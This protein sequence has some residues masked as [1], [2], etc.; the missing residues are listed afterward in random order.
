MAFADLGVST[1]IDTLKDDATGARGAYVVEECTPLFLC[2]VGRPVDMGDKSENRSIPLQSI[3]SAGL[4]NQIKST[5][6]RGERLSSLL[7]R[8]QTSHTGRG[9]GRPVAGSGVT[10]V[11][12]F[13]LWRSLD[14]LLVN[15]LGGTFNTH[16]DRLCGSS[17]LRRM[18]GNGRD[19]GSQKGERGESGEEHGIGGEDES[20]GKCLED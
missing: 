7:K 16:K 2:R 15:R 8:D 19:R 1:V 20:K 14:G 12:E 9:L 18:G 17:G 13:G 5:Y 3:A 4:S 10:V 6:V 11:G